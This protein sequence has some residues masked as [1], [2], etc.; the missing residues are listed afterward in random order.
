MNVI[1]LITIVS[2]A[3]LFFTSLTYS[4]NHDRT[5]PQFKNVKKD[6]ERFINYYYDIKLSPSEQK[7]LQKALSELKAP[8]CSDYSALTC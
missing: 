6:T 7:I 3:L 1:K 2:F 5:L 8:C 4:K